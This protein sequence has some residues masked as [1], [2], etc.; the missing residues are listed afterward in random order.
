[1]N[2]WFGVC[3]AYVLVSVVPALRAADDDPVLA[4]LDKAK[5]AYHADIE[6]YQV[7][8][9]ASFDRQEEAARKNGDKKLID[10]LKSERQ[11][12]VE[13]RELPKVA[14]AAFKFQLSSARSSLEAAYRN[15]VKEYI[16]SKQDDEAA[17]IE[18]EWDVFKTGGAV[19]ASGPFQ[20]KSVWMNDMPRMLLT[21]TERKGETFRATFEAEGEIERVVT[22]TV[23]DGEISWLAK[24]VRANKGSAGGDNH[25]T[26]TTD[27]VGDKIDFVWRVDNDHSGTFMLRLSKGK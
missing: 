17:A 19:V 4:K 12:F 27:K 25:G 14:P 8:V 21:V 9:A 18:K 10:Q 16:K 13:N 7:G 20:P 3:V 11:A 5:A 22:G 15:A 2:R 6:K 26:I 24:D 23:K 1:M